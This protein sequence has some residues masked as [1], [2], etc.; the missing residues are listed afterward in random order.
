MQKI[1]EVRFFVDKNQKNY[2]ADWLNNLDLKTKAR[3]NLRLVRLQYG[4]Y[5]DYKSLGN[6]LYELRFFFASGYRVYFTEH[7]NKII[8]ILCAGDKDTQKKDIKLAK[9]LLTELKIE[10]QNAK[11]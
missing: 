1:K 6:K 2:V 5:G 9:D 4:A 7:D 11:T 8:I 3:I 10:V